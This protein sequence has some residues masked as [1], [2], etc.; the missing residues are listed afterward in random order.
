MLK[1]KRV[2]VILRSAVL[3]AMPSLISWD[4]GT[5]DAYLWITG[6]VMTLW[7]AFQDVNREVKI[8]NLN[9]EN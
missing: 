9:A 1:R 4:W 8:K 2:Y 3:I 6:Y 5:D 7:V